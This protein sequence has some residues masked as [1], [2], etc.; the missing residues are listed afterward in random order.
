MLRTISY[1]LIAFLFF[2]IGASTMANAQWYDEW[3]VPCEHHGSQDLWQVVRYREG[4]NSWEKPK[5]DQ[6]TV[7][8]SDSCVEI[9]SNNLTLYFDVRKYIKETPAM[10]KVFRET[11]DEIF[12]YMEVRQGFGR[13][14]GLYI[15]MLGKLD[16]NGNMQGTIQIYC[17]PMTMANPPKFRPSVGGM[18]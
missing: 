12:D 6:G 14:K 18:H 9:L 3:V 16:D 11:P 15:L 10:F 2:I 4:L 13:D 5:P 1:R 8:W 7:R 17:K